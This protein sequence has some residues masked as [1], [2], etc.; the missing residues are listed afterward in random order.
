MYFDSGIQL[1]DI[2]S[3]S[4]GALW[5]VSIKFKGIYA[6]VPYILANV[7][8]GYA[9]LCA[10]VFLN[11][12]VVV[13]ESDGADA[14]KDKVLSYF[15]GDCPYSNQQDIGG[16]DPGTCQTSF[17][18]AAAGCRTSPA[19]LHP[20]VGFGGRRGQIPLRNASAT[21]SRRV[22]YPDLC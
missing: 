7:G 5:H 22:V 8:V 15:V 12:D 20:K 21:S 14:P 3:S 19:P 4:F 17:A 2:W 18:L 13:C 9:E 6:S 10:Q 1:L 16:T 11:N